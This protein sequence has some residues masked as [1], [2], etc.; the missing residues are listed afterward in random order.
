MEIV[1][2]KS[3]KINTNGRGRPPKIKIRKKLGF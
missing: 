3:G 2:L 1:T